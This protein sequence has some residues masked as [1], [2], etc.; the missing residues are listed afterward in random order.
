MNGLL[1][2]LQKRVT[3]R[4]E[5]ESVKIVEKDRNESHGMEGQIVYRLRGLTQLGS[6]PTIAVGPHPAQSQW[7]GQAGTQWAVTM[8]TH[9]PAVYFKVALQRYH[10]QVAEETALAR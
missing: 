6:P 7:A 3:G 4:S 8:S 9:Q 1:Q 5:N 10:H 2:R